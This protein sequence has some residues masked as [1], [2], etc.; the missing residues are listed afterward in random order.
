MTAEPQDSD[1]TQS[2]EIEH[3]FPAPVAAWRQGERRWRVD[4]SRWIPFVTTS[5]RF[6]RYGRRDPLLRR[7]DFI[8]NNSRRLP[9]HP[10]LLVDGPEAKW[11]HIQIMNEGC[12]CLKNG[13]DH[14]YLISYFLQEKETISCQKVIFHPTSIINVKCWKWMM[15]HESWQLK[16]RQFVQGSTDNWPHLNIDL[17]NFF[18]CLL[19]DKMSHQYPHDGRNEQHCKCVTI[20]Q[21]KYIEKQLTS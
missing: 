9:S 4:E 1:L 17:K 2:H 11:A 13:L 19:W 10:L 7:T 12:C 6:R 16:A 21:N 15:L 20:S 14:I 18:Q 3:N 8:Q 5:A